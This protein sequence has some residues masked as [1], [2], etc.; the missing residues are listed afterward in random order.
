MNEISL[1]KMMNGPDTVLNIYG[2][3]NQMTSSKGI[4]NWSDLGDDFTYYELNQNY[5]NTY[6]I[7]SFCNDMFHYNHLPIGIHGEE[8]RKISLDT[9]LEELDELILVNNKNRYAI[10]VK[11]SIDIV[12]KK[13]IDN[14]VPI[15]T[16]ASSKGMEFDIVYVIPE[17]MSRNEQYIAFTRA[18]SKLNIIE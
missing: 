4:I 14:K 13:Q 1:L 10:I 2:D 17:G 7:T 12:I 5:R 8:I 3:V 15:I 11:D 18:L 9:M 6:E 16:V